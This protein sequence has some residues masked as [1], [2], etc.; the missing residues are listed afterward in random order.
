MVIRKTFV[1]IVKKFVHIK[2]KVT[3]KFLRTDDFREKRNQVNFQAEKFKSFFE[4][5]TSRL[6]RFK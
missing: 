3:K 4:I 5:N 2:P 1:R 6:W